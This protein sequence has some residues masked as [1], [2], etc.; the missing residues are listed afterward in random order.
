MHVP[1]IGFTIAL[2]THAH[3]GQFDKAGVPY[4]EH[5]RAVGNALFD[6]GAGENAVHAGWLHDVVEDTPVTLEILAALGY[7]PEV[8]NAVDS[9]TRREG[10]T[11]MTMI[12]RA[13]ADPLGCV[14]KMADNRHNFGRLDHLS[15]EEAEFLGHR[16]MRA[17][18]ILEAAHEARTTQ[19]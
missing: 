10:E 7:P 8:L 3:R 6:Q 13:A 17:Y 14:V 2:A 12:R 19:G 15:T 1:S 9:V 11:Y 5:P 4:I 18:A 16:Y